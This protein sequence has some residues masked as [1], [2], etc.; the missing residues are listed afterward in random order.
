MPRRKPEKRPSRVAFVPK[1]VSLELTTKHTH[2]IFTIRRPVVKFVDLKE[3]PDRLLLGS[4]ERGY[5]R[6]F[7]YRSQPDKA[8][9][10]VGEEIIALDS[11]NWAKLVSL[12]MKIVWFCGFYGKR[13]KKYRHNRVICG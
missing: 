1:Q 9:L 11:W 10:S 8:F 2:R 6:A 4:M 7:A 3:N 12:V 5:V 13:A